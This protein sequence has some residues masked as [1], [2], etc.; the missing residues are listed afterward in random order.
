MTKRASSPSISIN[1]NTLHRHLGHL[2]IDNCHTLVNCW[3]VDGVDRVIREVE[4]CE[5]WAYGHSKQKDHPSMGT[6]TKWCLERVHINL[7]GPLPNL[8]GGNRYF[9]MIIDEHTHYQWVEFL[10]KKSDAFAQ[11]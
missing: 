3:L 4:F 8:L 10:P 9:L 1:I 11:L 5:G 2:G 7:C 6:T